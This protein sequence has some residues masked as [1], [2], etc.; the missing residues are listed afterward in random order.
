MTQIN[1][2]EVK[3]V[4]AKLNAEK[5]RQTS[6]PITSQGLTKN[7]TDTEA[8]LKYYYDK[9]G[10]AVDKFNKLRTNR[11]AALRKLLETQMV[12]GG[13]DARAVAT[14]IRQAMENRGNA[15]RLLSQ[16]STS[17]VLDTPFMFFGVESDLFIDKH[18]E[19][20]FNWCRIFAG[21]HHGSDDTIFAFYFSW[22]NNSQ[23]DAVIDASSALV[24]KGLCQ[25]IAD[26]GIFNGHINWLYLTAQL[27][28]IRWSGW[29]VDPQT[30]TTLDGTYLPPSITEHSYSNAVASLLVEGG[31]I[32]GNKGEKHQPFNAQEFDV[33]RDLMI[34]PGGATVVF[35]V[36]LR[37][38]Y[39]IEN[40]DEFDY[41]L[42]DFASDK[43]EN[44]VICPAVFLD[45]FT[46]LPVL[47]T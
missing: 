2:D 24:F 15:L 34:I 35:E 26:T 37:V 10:L 38:Q 18:F 5:I 21:K 40:G 6:I 43:T 12:N 7:R 39:N 29:G 45:L 32:F 33:S 4:S 17:I 1:I 22:P 44:R 47:T 19:S 13:K 25:V 3:R 30:G 31:G 28:V 16:P 8:L 20:F 27:D 36:S 14:G 11:H 42:M 9:T 23:F 41:L 46:V